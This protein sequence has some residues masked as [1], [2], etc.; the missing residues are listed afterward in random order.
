MFGI[1]DQYVDNL[2]KAEWAMPGMPS[3]KNDTTSI[4]PTH[5]YNDKPE[6]VQTKPP[7]NIDSRGTS[8]N[9]QY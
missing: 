3:T 5:N 2:V 9:E 8:T 1:S 4:H 7:T 6:Q